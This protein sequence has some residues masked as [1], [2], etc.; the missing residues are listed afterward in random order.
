MSREGFIV[1]AKS[2]LQKYKDCKVD[3]SLKQITEDLNDVLNEYIS[4]HIIYNID[5]P[6]EFENDLGKWKIESDG[7]IFL[8][9]NKI[10]NHIECNITILKNGDVTYGNE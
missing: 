8:F 2:T 5:F 10:L 3:E 4:N 1:T 9:P 6:I 7:R